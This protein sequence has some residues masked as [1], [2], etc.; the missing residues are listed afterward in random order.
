MILGNNIIDMFPKYEH[1]KGICFINDKH[2]KF[3]LY[4]EVYIKSLKM[5]SFLQAH[6]IEKMI[7]LYYN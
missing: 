5:L 2:D 7:R 3:I 1:K 4:S 6:G